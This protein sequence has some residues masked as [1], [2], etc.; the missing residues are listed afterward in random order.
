M[1]KFNVNYQIDNKEMLIGREP[2]DQ[3]RYDFDEPIEAESQEEA[4]ALALQWFQEQSSMNSEIDEEKERI[5]FY[6]DEEVIS[7]YYNFEA[8]ED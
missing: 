4:I 8:E 2:H 1:K 3:T 5:T 6:E 7:Q